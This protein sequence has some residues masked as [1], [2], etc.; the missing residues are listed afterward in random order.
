MTPDSNTT[1]EKEVGELSR[2]WSVRDQTLFRASG[3]LGETTRYER[4]ISPTVLQTAL[5]RAARTVRE[6]PSNRDGYAVPLHEENRPVATDEYVLWRPDKE[7]L[8]WYD[9]SFGIDGT[10]RFVSLDA[11]T[12]TTIGTRLK[13]WHPELTPESS[14]ELDEFDLPESEVHPQSKLSETECE[15]FFEE[16][17]EF[18]ESER[19]TERRA[20]RTQ[21][22]SND[23]ETLVHRGVAVGPFVSLGRVNRRDDLGQYRLQITEEDR[24]QADVNLYRDEGIYPDSVYLVDT[25]GE[26][27]AF[28]LVVRTT[29]V[30]GSVL[31]VKPAQSCPRDPSTV[32][33]LLT[34]GHREYYLTHLLNPVPFERRTDALERI[35]SNESKRD[36]LTGNRPVR[37]GSDE[38]SVPSV[39]MELNEYQ[40][41][42][43]KWADDADDLLCIHGPPGTGKTRT[44]TAYVLH[45]VWHGDTVL[46][47]AHSN[48]AVDNLLV[49]DSTLDEPEPDTLHDFATRSNDEDGERDEGSEGDEEGIR[50]A[51]VG[52]NSNNDVVNQHYAN[53]SVA[54]ADVVAATTNGA[55]QFDTDQFDVGVVDEATQAS[56]PATAI[57]LDCAEKLVLSGD[58]KQLPPYCADESMKDEQLHVSL[59]EH[60]LDRY[61]DEISVLLGRQYRM[62]AAIAEFPNEAFYDGELETADHN[63]DWQIGDLDPLVGIDIDGE[64]KRVS[65]GHS[66][67][68]LAEVESVVEE[69]ERLV[70]NGVDAE[71]VGV[72]SMYRG[73]IG[74]IRSRLR[75]TGIDG[76]G[77][78]TVDTVDSFQ[79]GERE[80]IVVSFVRSNDEGRSGFLEFGDEGAR[81]LNVALT[82][83]RKRLVLVGDWETLSAVAPNRTAENSCAELY[84]ELSEQLARE[85]RLVDSR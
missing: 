82:R 56:R 25:F 27:D 43:L 31:T 49:G 21:H 7:Q 69:V 8:G 50:I 73:Q 68:N 57:V 74:K 52:Q 61:G 76:I 53:T 60:L 42:A 62:H 14:Q 26:R 51:R 72:I 66:L 78:V 32:E 13:Y 9:T 1:P 23:L 39:E 46:V 3:T 64:E 30:D 19:E 10:V 6:T 80:A 15:S 67:Y 5:D 37:F 75:E 48:Q 17:Y 58:H 24:Q 4:N 81:R 33:K 45:A 44:L 28:P 77:G 22:Q 79:G 63:R 71:D 20:N 11:A 85:G 36:L 70:S 55:A 38:L 34:D 84:D 65:G 16:L 41:Q 59:F 2:N 18:V 47:T 40:Q 12:E 83:A 35:Q 54:E 29:H